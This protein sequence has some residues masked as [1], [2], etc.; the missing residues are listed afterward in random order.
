[1]ISMNSVNKIILNFCH[2]LAQLCTNTLPGW[3]GENK[4]SAVLLFFP[5]H[6]LLEGFPHRIYNM[7]V[8]N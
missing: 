1:M 5:L 8:L 2:M 3:K 6:K 7:L 4:T